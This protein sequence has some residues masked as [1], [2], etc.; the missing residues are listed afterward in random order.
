MYSTFS[1]SVFMSWSPSATA[2][3]RQSGLLLAI[4]RARFFLHADTM[5]G[6]RAVVAVV[7]AVVAS[8]VVVEVAGVD[9]VTPSWM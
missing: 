8:V 2:I 6:A 1:P 3:A 9:C 5:V 4:I 7:V